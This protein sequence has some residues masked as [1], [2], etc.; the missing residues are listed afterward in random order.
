MAM[1]RAWAQAPGVAEEAKLVTGT[2][3]R[4]KL[5]HERVGGG[6]HRQ[7]VAGCSPL[8]VVGEVAGTGL[9]QVP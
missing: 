7:G 6:D 9:L 5:H 3:A 2:H 1:P 8:L 4:P